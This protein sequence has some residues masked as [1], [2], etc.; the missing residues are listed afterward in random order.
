MTLQCLHHL[1]KK[2]ERHYLERNR[3]WKIVPEEQ[4]TVW[5]PR[6]NQEASSSKVIWAHLPVASTHLKEMEAEKEIA[7]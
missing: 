5:Q 4:E 2:I 6:P 7:D 1:K 3:A